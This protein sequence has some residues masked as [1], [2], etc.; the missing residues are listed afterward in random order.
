MI[1]R[2]FIHYIMYRHPSICQRKTRGA[3]NNII[4]TVDAADHHYDAGLVLPKVSVGYHSL[5]RTPCCGKKEDT[6]RVTRRMTRKYLLSSTVHVSA[7]ES[8]RPKK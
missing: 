5:C 6:A 4:I 2:P 7:K 1:P 8:N 3:K